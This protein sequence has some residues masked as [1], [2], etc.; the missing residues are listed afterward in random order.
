MATGTFVA[1]VIAPRI[2]RQIFQI[3]PLPALSFAG[4]LDE[5]H[6]AAFALWVIA[7]V[8]FE[9]IKRCRKGRDLRGSC[10]GPGLFAASGELRIDDGCERGENHEDEQHFNEGERATVLRVDD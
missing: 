3:W 6:Q 2:F 1:V 5:I 7:I 9:R 10:C 8:H 4:L